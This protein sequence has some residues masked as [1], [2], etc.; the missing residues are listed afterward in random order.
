MTPP[1]NFDRVRRQLVKQAGEPSADPDTTLSVTKTQPEDRYTFGVLYVPGARDSDNEYAEAD[2]LQKAVWQYVRKGER[3][4]RDTHTNQTIGEMVEIVSWPLEV[5]VPVT[6]YGKSSGEEVKKYKLPANTVFAGVIWD[7]DAWT[8][9]KRGRLRGYSLGGR[10]IRL[11]DAMSD[12]A[13]PKMADMLAE[14]EVTKDAPAGPIPNKPGK[15]NWIE[16]AGGLD[17][18]IERI[19]ED[20]KPKHGV[21][22][23]IRLAWGIVKRWCKGG[24]NVTAKTRAKA[25][26]AVANMEAKQARA[27]AKKSMDVEKLLMETIDKS[28]EPTEDE[29]NAAE[30][31]L[32]A[33]TLAA[34]LED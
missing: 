26:K 8:E 34:I 20:L 1:V 32:S 27:H 30:A 25:C 6:G 19:A 16:E 18:Y 23:A 24:G 21:S 22:G 11:Q 31:N 2:D 3:R 9:V 5:V 15:T 14:P 28:G 4:I 33:T 17:P 13:L 10:A 29:L 12:E 7:D